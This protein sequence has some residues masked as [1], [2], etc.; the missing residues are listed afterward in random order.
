MCAEQP[1]LHRRQ[2]VALAGLLSHQPSAHSKCRMLVLGT[3]VGN[4]KVG[5]GRGSSP[6]G[7]STGVHG[8]TGTCGRKLQREVRGCVFVR[9]WGVS[10]PTVC[11]AV[12]VA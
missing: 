6:E 3:E 2:L 7:D 4:D 1:C 8:G 5:V 12:C 10:V 9:D 11:V